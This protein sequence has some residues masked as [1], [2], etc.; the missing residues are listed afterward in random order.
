MYVYNCIY[1]YTPLSTYVEHALPVDDRTFGWQDED[2]EG[3]EQLCNASGHGR[4]LE[5]W[6]ALFWGPMGWSFQWG[7]IYIDIYIDICNIYI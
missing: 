7:N 1:I 4:P 2:P 6:S 3:L 5:G